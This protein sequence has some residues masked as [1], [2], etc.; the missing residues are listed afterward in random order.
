MLYK[1]VGTVK[2]RPACIL[3]MSEIS[4]RLLSYVSIHTIRLCKTVDRVKLK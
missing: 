4:L 3:A 1:Y 2:S